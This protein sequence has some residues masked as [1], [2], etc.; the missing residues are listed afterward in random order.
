MNSK[1]LTN[2][3][4]KTGLKIPFYAVHLVAVA[5]VIWLGW[6]WTG[7]ALALAL[8]VVRMFGVTAG[9]HRYF[10]HRTFRTS[11][12][13]QFLLALLG[14]TAIQKGVLW[15]AAHH[16]RHHKHSDEP[17]DI[18]SVRQRGF[19]WAHMG[20]FLAHD[21]NDT[22]WDRIKDLS[23]FPELKWLNR[24]HM[25]PV[26]ALAV[27]LLVIG[28]AWALTWGFFVS[29]VLLWHGTFTINSLAHVFGRR[30]YVTSDDSRNSWIL[31]LI[32]LGEGWHNNHHHYQRSVNQGFYWWEFDFSY[33]ALRVMSWFRLVRDLHRTPRH[34]RDI[35]GG[36]VVQAPVPE[37]S[38]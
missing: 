29:T 12:V 4:S 31:A 32:T 38:V 18:H 14:T 37:L 35:R 5:G 8:Y 6:S 23:R 24:W 3:F 22:D 11:R 36:D 17:E 34:V 10:S 30:R 19:L 28:G 33:Y 15:W 25:V 20:W 13:M 9:Y 2:I 16:R 26:V 21:H 27:L 7:V 1:A